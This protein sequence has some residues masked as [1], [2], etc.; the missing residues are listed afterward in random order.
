LNQFRRASPSLSYKGVRRFCIYE[1]YLSPKLHITTTH[2][3]NNVYEDV[4]LIGDYMVPAKNHSKVESQHYFPQIVQ[5]TFDYLH[6]KHPNLNLNV[7]QYDEIRIFGWDKFGVD[8]D[9]VKFDILEILAKEIY[10]TEHKFRYPIE[11]RIRLQNTTQL[12]SYFSLNH[13]RIEFFFDVYNSWLRL[14]VDR[15]HLFRSPHIKGDLSFLEKYAL[16][17]SQ[18]ITG[19]PQLKRDIEENYSLINTVMRHLHS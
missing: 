4:V 1:A 13:Y 8:F 2:N 9:S 6:K 5:L 3:F 15:S 17:Y 14:H 12:L 11:Q 19:L 7:G 18:P 16:D 10:V